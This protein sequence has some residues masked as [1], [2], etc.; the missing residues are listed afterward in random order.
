MFRLSRASATNS[1]A[2]PT[3]VCITSTISSRPTPRGRASF[4]RQRRGDAL[5]DPQVDVFLPTRCV[6]R[7]GKHHL[8]LPAAFDLGARA[9][10]HHHKSEGEQ[11]G[12]CLFRCQLCWLCVNLHGFCQ[13][14]SSFCKAHRHSESDVGRARQGSHRVA[15]PN[16][17]RWTTG[18][19]AQSSTTP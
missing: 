7:V 5:A 17:R 9:C 14:R 3:R 15:P 11:R 16:C 1:P 4:Q 18:T 8:R 6:G 10:K 19:P 2:A 12:R 13:S